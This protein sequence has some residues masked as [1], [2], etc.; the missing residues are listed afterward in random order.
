[1]LS[2]K[3][4][5]RKLLRQIGTDFTHFYVE[6]WII[7]VARSPANF[8]RPT[9]KMA[10]KKRILR[11]F[12]HQSNASLS[13]YT[14]TGDRFRWNLNTKRESLSS[15]IRSEQNCAI[16]PITN[17]L[18]RN[19]FVGFLAHFR[20]ARSGIGGWPLCLE[21]ILA[22]LLYS[23]GQGCFPSV[24]FSCDLPLSKYTRC[25]RAKSFLIS[26]TLRKFAIFWLPI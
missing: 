26:G 4:L 1:M 20:F 17:H 2:Y 9:R 19:S 22:L 5:F 16:C 23:K 21:R 14:L 25:R 15:W 3:S 8:W 12:C 6:T 13:L 7:H 11:S 24:T 18:P 10:R